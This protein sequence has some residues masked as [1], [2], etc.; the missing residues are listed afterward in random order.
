[1]RC[2]P[3]CGGF[4]ALG[5]NVWGTR[6]NICRG[7][8]S[9]LGG[10]G[11]VGGSGLLVSS[12]FF[13]GATDEGEWEKAADQLGM[14]F[15]GLLLESCRNLTSQFEQE[16]RLKAFTRSLAESGEIFGEDDVGGIPNGGWD[17]ATRLRGND[18]FE[19]FEVSG[20]IGQKRCVRIR[21]KRLNEREVAE[22][23]EYIVGSRREGN[24]STHST[25][26]EE[27]TA[28]MEAPGNGGT[29]GN[30]AFEASLFSRRGV[31]ASDKA[32]GVEDEKDTA[33]I[34]AGELANH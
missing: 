20:K 34:F 9:R 1:M 4:G 11:G 12:L 24:F 19:G 30:G 31:G 10:F 5:R 23:R 26:F 18:Y 25:K 15:H 14:D 33:I 13:A 16:I 17:G 21:R 7:S 27:S 6:G 28:L 32:V 2:R 8:G 29:E 22:N 3:V